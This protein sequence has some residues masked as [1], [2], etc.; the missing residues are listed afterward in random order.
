MQHASCSIPG[1]KIQ[2]FLD[3]AFGLDIMTKLQSGECQMMENLLLMKFDIIKLF[4]QNH[5]IT[6]FIFCWRADQKAGIVKLDLWRW[7][8]FWL[9]SILL[10][11]FGKLHCE[12]R[13]IP[14]CSGSH[15]LEG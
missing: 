4:Q 10:P 14:F 7:V 2:P 8:M 12:L 11:H 3:V 13:R 5:A 15:V 1:V 6:N 9:V